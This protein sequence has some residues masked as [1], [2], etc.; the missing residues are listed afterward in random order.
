MQALA[1]EHAAASADAAQR[2]RLRRGRVGPGPARA[3]RAAGEPID[4]QLRHAFRLCL[5]RAPDEE[6]LSILRNVSTTRSAPRAAIRRCQDCWPRMPVPRAGRQADEFAAWYAV[7]AALLNL[8]ETITK[9]LT[10]CSRLTTILRAPHSP[11]LPRPLGLGLGAMALGS[12]LKRRPG[13]GRIAASGDPLAAHAGHFA[14]RAKHVIYLHMIGAPSQLDLFDHKPALDRRDGQTVPRGTDSRQAVRLHRR[15]VKLAGSPFKF[16]RHGQSGQ[17]I[18]ELLPHLATRGRR[19]RHRPSL[20]TDAI[21]HAPA[22]MFL[23]TGFGRGGRPSFGSWVDV[24]PRFGESRPARLRRPSLGPARRRGH[25]SSGRAAFCRAS[26]RASSSAPAAT[27]C[28]FS[29]IPR[30]TPP[31]IAAACSTPSRR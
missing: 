2:S 6:E 27:R 16:A 26:T 9:G 5:A 24:R 4:E 22:Q 15:R 13:G 10:P 17:E 11:R 3:A 29:R 18:S 21:N 23:H 31:P 1:L 28:C 8:D 14:P 20:H 30:G 12:L 7:A 19:H 25:V